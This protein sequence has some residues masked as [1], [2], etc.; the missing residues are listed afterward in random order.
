MILKN[1]LIFL[2][3]FFI[4]LSVSGVDFTNTDT[5]IGATLDYPDLEG[6]VLC[7]IKSSDL[8]VENVK[9]PIDKYLSYITTT[10]QTVSC[11]GKGNL[12]LETTDT[13]TIGS[14]KMYI[15]E[16]CCGFVPNKD[17]A[18]IDTANS[19]WYNFYL[20]INKDR[21]YESFRLI[22]DCKE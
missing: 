19:C 17:K 8:N 15:N 1:S 16:I 3:F 14:K 4:L 10:A 22:Y 2:I 18:M 9:I 12:K 11:K 5:I 21:L 7:S 13:K 6:V 20:T